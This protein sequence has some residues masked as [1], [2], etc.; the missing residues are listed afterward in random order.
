MSLRKTLLVLLA[1]LLGGV[2]GLSWYWEKQQESV[3]TAPVITG[4]LAIKRIRVISGHEFDITLEDGKRMKG[5]LEVVT[6]TGAGSEVTKKVTDLIN[7]AVNPK[8]VLL[9]EGKVD[10]LL[11]VNNKELSLS[12]W[13]KDNKLVWGE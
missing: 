5:Q 10:I 7:S 2:I 8:V 9:R 11:T 6:P 4:T 12:K 13:L 1:I 3:V